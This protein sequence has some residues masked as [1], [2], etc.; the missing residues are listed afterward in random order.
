MSDIKPEPIKSVE[1]IGYEDHNHTRIA[2]I[3]VDLKNGDYADFDLR[4]R[5][6]T[7]EDGAVTYRLLADLS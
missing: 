3:R 4:A 1:V 6:Y 5:S 7:D 2:V